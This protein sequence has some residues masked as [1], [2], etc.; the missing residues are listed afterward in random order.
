MRCSVHILTFH[1]VCSNLPH[2]LVR[3][4]TLYYTA[5]KASLDSSVGISTHYELDGPGVG[6]LP[7]PV[8]ARSKASVCGRCFAGISGSNLAGGMD[9]SVVCCTIKT[10]GKMQDFQDKDTSTDEL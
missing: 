2:G 8:A 1:Y 5:R 7:I 9:V 10:K 6:I 3:T 4:F